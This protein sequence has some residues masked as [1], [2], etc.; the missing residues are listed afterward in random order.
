MATLLDPTRAPAP[1]LPTCSSLGLALS[2]VSFVTGI[3]MFLGGLLLPSS[4]AHA[5]IP[6]AAV[7][8]AANVR[9]DAI[10]TPPQI[11]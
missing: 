3:S 5:K 10:R 4:R 9:F 1:S 8:R 6:Q 11:T 2:L 7:S